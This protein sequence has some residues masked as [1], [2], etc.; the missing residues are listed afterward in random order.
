[1]LDQLVDTEQFPCK[2]R[3]GRRSAGLIH[4]LM[5]LRVLRLQEK[6]TLQAPTTI[7]DSGLKSDCPSRLQVPG[8]LHAVEAHP[9]LRLQIAAVI[10]ARR[11]VA[12]LYLRQ[13]AEVAGLQ[14]GTPYVS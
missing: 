5:Q 14:R 3:E 11:P 4:A 6:E 10:A 7:I 1:M 8:S 12:D 2:R 9:Q 13:R